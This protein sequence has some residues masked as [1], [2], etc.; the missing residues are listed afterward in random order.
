MAAIITATDHPLVR[1]LR[2]LHDPAGRRSAQAVLV[3]GRRAV[4]GFLAAGWIAHDLLVRSGETVPSEWPP[5]NVSAI[6]DRVARRLSQASTASGYFGVFAIATAPALLPAAGGLVLAGVADPGNL[7]TLLRCAAAFG[8][9]QV[10][11]LGGADPWGHKAVQ[12]TAGALA[13]IDL[14]IRAADDLLVDCAGGAAL[15]ALVVAG[16]GDPA[17]A[18]RQPRWLV[19]GG[20][21]NGMPDALLA[22][23]SE[24]LS[25]PMRGA[26]ESLNAAVAGAI[27]LYLLGR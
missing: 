24:R 2:A 16:G 12:A 27:A 25:L 4:T 13:A 26:I 8:V 20:E 21:A 6:N 17:L 3:E 9:R 10:M 7:G 15:T 22:R 1:R 11:C 18:P 23:C 19:V 5:A 14:H